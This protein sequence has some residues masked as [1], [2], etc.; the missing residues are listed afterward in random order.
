[1]ERSV[2]ELLE[3]LYALRAGLSVAYKMIKGADKLENEITSKR[4]TYEASKNNRKKRIAND[5]GSADQYLR[6]IENRIDDVKETARYRRKNLILP[7]VIATGI[8]LLVGGVLALL[9]F[10][11]LPAIADALGNDVFHFPAWVYVA[12]TISSFGLFLF[13]S[14]RLRLYSFDEYFPFEELNRL[15]NQLEKADRNMERALDNCF[16]ASSKQ[17]QE[18]QRQ[19]QM[20]FEKS[21]ASLEKQ[22]TMKK[23]ER[24][25]AR[26]VIIPTLKKEYGSILR[27]ENWALLDAVIYVLSSQR[28]TT[29]E[30]ALA[31]YDIR[32]DLGDVKA[33]LDVIDNANKKIQNGIAQVYAQVYSM[34]GAI[35]KEF[36]RLSSQ[37]RETEGRLST[38]LKESCDAIIQNEKL[39]NASLRKTIGEEAQKIVISN[40]RM[41]SVVETNN[42]LLSEAN[43]SSRKIAEAI[44]RLR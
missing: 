43:E 26:S 27:Y 15:K 6:Y 39:M 29:V 25:Y 16:M 37:L 17:E 11:A 2:D 22:L 32:Q 31:Y 40:N 3:K 20:L 7:I 10:L 13:K 9:D 44:D 12:L 33:R 14:E 24:E 28:A 4:A 23:I 1:M 41:I 5:F 36:T 21:L 8:A 30:S 34:S 35:S 19:E 18:R 38:R 42:G